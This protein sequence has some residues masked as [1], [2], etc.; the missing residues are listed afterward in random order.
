[1][2][3]IR[4]PN[5]QWW[6]VLDGAALCL[7]AP[8]VFDQLSWFALYFARRPSSIPPPP[9]GLRIA[10]VTTYVAGV[11]PL[12]MV[13]RTLAA[14]VA[15]QIPHA[16]WLLDESDS[17]AARTLCQRLGVRHFTR[18]GA[19][20]YN[21]PSGR[22]EA[23]SKHGNYNAWLD[24]V[25]FAGY[26]LIAAFD[27]DHVPSPRF[28]AETTGFFAD[29]RVGYVQAAQA[30]YNQDASFIAR[31]AA[32]ETYAYYSIV[33]MASA[34]FRYP[35]VTGCHN[36]HRATALRKVGG[37][38]D[39]A[40]DDLLLTLRYQ[41]AGWEGV[42]VPKILA[43]GLAPVNWSGYLGQQF[44][45]ARAVTDLKLRRP[46]AARRSGPGPRILSL[47]QGVRYFLDGA[48]VLA[49]GSL[50][51]LALATGQAS[52]FLPPLVVSAALYGT[53]ALTNLYKQRFYLDPDRESGLPWRSWILRFAKWPYTVRAV[54]SAL[55]NRHHQYLITPKSA[56]VRP[57]D[58]LLRPM[59]A[60]TIPVLTAWVAGWAAGRIEGWPLH[61]FALAVVALPLAV[62]ATNR[63]RFPAPY[64]PSR[65]PDL[66][67]PA[68]RPTSRLQLASAAVALAAGLWSMT[69][70]F[71]GTV[72][73]NDSARHAM[74]GAF[75]LDL[76]H[77]GHLARP[78]NFARWYFAHFPAISIPY[79]PPLFPAFE[80]LTYAVTGVKF[81]AA[82]LCIAVAVS[83]AAA[84]A[85]RLIFAISGSI[86][87]GV[88]ATAVLLGIPVAQG[89]ARSVM[90]EFP[91]LVFVLWA[92]LYWRRWR[93]EFTPARGVMYGLIAGAGIWTKQTIFLPLIP[94]LDL[95]LAREWRG[96]RQPGIWVSGVVG[97]AAAAALLGLAI[98]G[99]GHALPQHWAAVPWG[100]SVSN[101]FR[102]YAASALPAGVVILLIAAGVQVLRISRKRV[103]LRSSDYA[104][105]RLLLAWILAAGTVVLL[106]PAFDPR[107]AIFAIPAVIGLLLVLSFR[108]LENLVSRSAAGAIICAGA[109]A[110]L[111]VTGLD[112][113][114]HL[115]GPDV[116][117]REAVSQ[118]LKRFLYFGATNGA[119]SYSLRQVSA[120]EAPLVLRGDKLAEGGFTPDRLHEIVSVYAVQ[121]VFLER[122]SRQDW[123]ELAKRLPSTFEYRRRYVLD[124][125][126]PTQRGELLEYRIANSR[127]SSKG[128]LRQTIQSFGSSSESP[129]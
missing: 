64:D 13:E 121:A 7:L 127:P 4:F 50:A 83:L 36:V 58:L 100:E 119:F 39:H 122:N 14:M 30:Y 62:A 16:T 48:F 18:R 128:I 106:T 117:A 40:A 85:F 26:D 77:G 104:D 45:W 10:A 74:N 103:A 56:T 82:R 33:Q 19:P 87:V 37:F 84:L 78:V 8:A 23:G 65:R 29:A 123:L 112:R 61:A 71:Q 41:G 17:V 76:V 90:L 12:E 75:L 42:F 3:L 1:L 113:A 80:A 111:A 31:G 73:D 60:M 51:C 52:L 49:A 99:G 44:R 124:S 108:I 27:P 95:A 98:S 20:E 114:P 25:G 96:L 72:A 55:R 53:L 38:A 116:A 66:S 57:P 32:E 46:D 107:Y 93:R 92:V 109:A 9:S 15:M 59:L 68:P 63:L 129:I 43:R 97:G 2:A 35:V 120:G 34:R 91:A 79:H 5:M 6:P 24:R 101:N 94:F 89:V 102:K 21:T 28:L 110:I 22:F 115:S 11:E 86:V 118:D 126:D 54:L 105:F 47:L 69:G 70:T 81:W 125:S 88:A 67:T